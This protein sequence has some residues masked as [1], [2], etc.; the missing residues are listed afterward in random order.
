M[1]AAMLVALAVLPSSAGAAIAGSHPMQ[2]WQANGRVDVI[3][4][5]GTTAYIGG[6]FTAMRPAG[7]AA[8]TGEVA[9]GRAAAIDLTTGALLPWDPNASARVDAIAVD[10]ATVYL[11]GTF[12]TVGG[13][14]RRRI[15]AVDAV[16][17]SATAFRAS[18]NGEVRALAVAG[19]TLYA[20]GGFTTP[21]A[22]AAAFDPVTGSHR[23]TWAATTDGPVDAITATADGSR[24]V[25]G[26]G[27][28]SLDGAASSA[29]GAVDPAT[30][31]SMLWSWH[32]PARFFTTHPFDVVA[33]AADASGVYAAGTGNGGSFLKFDPATGSPI[34]AGG[35]DGNVV[36]VALLDG[37]AYFGGHFN[38]YCGPMMG[39]NNCS[40]TA[41]G[42]ALRDKLIAVD[43]ATGAL[44]AWHPS[45]NS[46]LGVF[47]LGSGGGAVAAGGD[48]TKLGGASQQGF[49]A[50]LE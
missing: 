19:G 3:T 43:A 38:V 37:V 10:G 44:Q 11:G 42:A 34:Y 32:G 26:G 4:I 12:A 17:G 25:L 41:P 8:G 13:K 48:F 20:G 39:Y 45:A 18:V 40:S 5:S 6:S 27:F 7:A 9:R 28:N 1:V 36:A 16:T 31:A 46:S 30:G 2:S 29:I 22:Y 24:I 15:A 33:L 50:F 14:T 35:A 47:A 21:Q 23:A 49:G